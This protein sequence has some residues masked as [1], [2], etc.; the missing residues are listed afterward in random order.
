MV[1]ITTCSLP[2]VDE[3]QSR[4]NHLDALEPGAHAP[5]VVVDAKLRPLGHI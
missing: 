1:F 5:A 4:G 3:V 2:V